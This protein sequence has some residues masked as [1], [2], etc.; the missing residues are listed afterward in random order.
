MNIACLD[1]G[2]VP[3]ALLAGAHQEM[4]FHSSLPVARHYVE[5][6]LAAFFGSLSRRDRAG[7]I[8]AL[9]GARTLAEDFDGELFLLTPEETID[10]FVQDSIT[11][12][13]TTSNLSLRHDGPAI[14]YTGTYQCWKTEPAPRCLNL[15]TFHGR[16]I[17]GPQVWRWSEHVFDYLP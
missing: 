4:V 7:L 3:T 5:N 9:Q 13:I 11:I 16:L 17:T 1:E 12:F 10:R 8:A 2:G 6:L 15:G 14:R